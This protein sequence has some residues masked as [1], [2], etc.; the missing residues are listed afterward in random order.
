MIIIIIIIYHHQNFLVFFACIC[1]FLFP[2]SS[3]V[4]FVIGLRA[5]KFAR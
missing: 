4:L 1:G 3:S 5:V 2:F